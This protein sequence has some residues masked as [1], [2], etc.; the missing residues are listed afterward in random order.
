M[1]DLVT[2]WSSSAGGPYPV[3]QS[4]TANKPLYITG[5]I[6]ADYKLMGGPCIVFDGVND[7]LTDSITSEFTEL[8]VSSSDFTMLSFMMYD[9]DAGAN[10]TLLGSW[11]DKAA[12]NYLRWEWNETAGEHRSNVG[13]SVR[14]ISSS[15]SQSAMILGHQ[16]TAGDG[17]TIINNV[18]GV[19]GGGPSSTDMWRFAAY[20]HGAPAGF[21]S[22][23]I[24][25][26]L[27]A[28]RALQTA[29]I[30]GY[31]RHV[32]KTY[33][34]PT[35]I[36]GLTHRWRADSGV[37][38]NAGTQEASSWTDSV[39]NYT[40]PGGF[41]GANEPIFQSFDEGFANNRSYMSGTTAPA[42]FRH[43]VD[44]TIE[45]PISASTYSGPE[46][47]VFAVIYK[48]KV[49][50][51]SIAD[52]LHPYDDS[53]PEDRFLFYIN[54]NFFVTYNAKG[55]GLSTTYTSTQAISGSLMAVVAVAFKNSGTASF[56]VNGAEETITSTARVPAFNLTGSQFRLMNRTGNSKSPEKLF[57]FMT[58]NRA[59][60]FAEMQ[61][62]TAYARLYY[63][64]D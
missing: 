39:G 19:H 46:H 23:A 30:E 24:S 18:T 21:M 61:N 9:R 55:G 53:T 47:T 50:E 49:A 45:I 15:L 29:E 35:K 25:E 20:G 22:G 2:A 37:A 34:N 32:L 56:C 52:F 33:L 58:F 41:S 43:N 28:N 12:S 48:H 64:I 17:Y 51:E 59:L 4:T 16:E 8:P 36:S 14:Y 5:S 62:L 7:E 31:R 3:S 27:F 6:N 26:A 10:N 11:G 1:P 44:G 54:G 13:G 40:I 63:G 42:Q 60:S 38:L 57:E